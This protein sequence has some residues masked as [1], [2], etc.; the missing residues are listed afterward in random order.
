MKNN[1]LQIHASMR[2]SL[3]IFYLQ[4]LTAIK[5]NTLCSSIYVDYSEKAKVEV[6][7]G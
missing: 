7:S 4:L 3:K 5:V 6:E 1:K 2:V